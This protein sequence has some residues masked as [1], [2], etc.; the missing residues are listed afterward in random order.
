MMPIAANLGLCCCPPKYVIKSDSMIWLTSLP[1]NRKPVSIQVSIECRMQI[2]WFL[3]KEFTHR[4]AFELEL[5]L[6][7]SQRSHWVAEKHGLKES[8]KT[9]DQQIRFFGGQ[10]L[11]PRSIE[12]SQSTPSVFIFVHQSSFFTRTH[13]LKGISIQSRKKPTQLGYWTTVE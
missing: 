11:Q 3:P 2:S 9:V 13:F 8:E 5:F 12:R 6:N 7:G 4:L 1:D 10:F